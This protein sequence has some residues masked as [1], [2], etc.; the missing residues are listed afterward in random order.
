M[1]MQPTA[2]DPEDFNQ[3]LKLNG[4][5][6]F[7]SWLDLVIVGTIEVAKHSFRMKGNEASSWDPHGLQDHDS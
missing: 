2:L 3:I 7:F 5:R 6:W 1:E 4:L